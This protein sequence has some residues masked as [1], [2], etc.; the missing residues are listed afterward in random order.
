VA[1]G[2]LGRHVEAASALRD[3]IR[4]RSNYAEAHNN[5][6]LALSGLGEIDAAAE[7]FRTAMRL[8][9]A[10]IEAIGNLANLFRDAGRVGEAIE[11]YRKAVALW[12]RNIKMLWSLV[13]AMEQQG[14]L[15]EVIEGLRMLVELEP[16]G[17]AVAHSALLYTLHYHPGYDRAALFTEHQ[18]WAR[19]HAPPIA[20]QV[21]PSRTGARVRI[22]YVSPDFRDH[23]VPRFIEGALTC[24]DRSQFEI[25]CY[26]DVKREDAVTKRLRSLP[27][28]WRETA[29]QSDDAV[30]QIIRGDG[31]DILVDLRGHA[32]GNRLTLFARKVAT[33][34]V[35]MVGYF[36]TTGLPQMDWR[37]TDDVQ[38]PPGVTERYHSEG[39]IRIPVSCWHYRPDDDA[40]EVVAMPSLKKGYV[41]FGSF[42]KLLKISPACGRL[43]A[44]VLH[45]VPRSRLLIPIAGSDERNVVRNTLALYGIPPDR[46][47]LVS[48]QKTRREYLERFGSI[49]LALD[50]FPFNGITT[51]C[52]GLYMGVPVVSL[53]GDTSVS[54]A[55]KSIVGAAELS[56]LVA[57]TKDEFV[58]KA[59]ALAGDEDRRQRL[60]AGMRGRLW[61]SRLLDAVAF[62]ASLELAF[63][64]TMKSPRMSGAFR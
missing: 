21:F 35:S 29:G 48:R 57:N 24:H 16:P 42:N 61:R 22:G 34:Q 59:V 14:Q 6:G 62:T 3:A 40:P 46:L 60:R 7:A 2:R 10:Y 43:W 49:D 44:G 51:T 56:E 13:K 26:S 36:D 37:V 9:P 64:A 52:D 47:D 25:F 15:D 11:L 8:R 1:L 41:T 33:V 27:V 12:P 18:E 23:T 5:L 54:R 28:C 19:R 39:L 55:G 17:T 45:A 31:I 58:A 4:L 32:A 63:L 50:T 20:R 30:E 53:A 38:D